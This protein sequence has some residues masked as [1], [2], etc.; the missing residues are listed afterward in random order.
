MKRKDHPW[1]KFNIFARSRDKFMGDYV[2]YVS[3][4]IYINKKK[5]MKFNAEIVR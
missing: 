4:T 3:E 5:Q 1:R 2:S